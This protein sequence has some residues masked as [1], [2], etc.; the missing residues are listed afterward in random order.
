MALF[1]KDNHIYM[2]LFLAYVYYSGI[3]DKAKFIIPQKISLLFFLIRLSLFFIYPISLD[4]ILGCIL[5]FLLF[6]IIAALLNHNMGGDIKFMGVIGLWLGLELTIVVTLL[7]IILISLVTLYEQFV[8]KTKYQ[9]PYG[10]FVLISSVL[11]L[12]YMR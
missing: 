12:L 9:I 6:W 7:A 1:I 3:V 2:T 5:P 11:V 4:N 8:A 10:Y